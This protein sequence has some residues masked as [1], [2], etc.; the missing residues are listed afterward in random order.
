MNVLGESYGAGRLA[1]EC[2]NCDRKLFWFD[3]MTDL[4]A[5]SVPAHRKL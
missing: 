5:V 2:D 3:E 1:D 4:A